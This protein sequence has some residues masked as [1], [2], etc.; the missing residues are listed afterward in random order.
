MSDFNNIKMM[1]QD[2][3]SLLSQI[4][5]LRLEADAYD[6][7]TLS[8]LLDLAHKEALACSGKPLPRAMPMQTTTLQ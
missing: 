7:A 8:C 3:K 4:E 5:V 1:S 2:I 6:F